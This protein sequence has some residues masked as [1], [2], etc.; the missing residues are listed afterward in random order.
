MHLIVHDAPNGLQGVYDLSS[1]NSI[2]R[3]LDEARVTPSTILRAAADFGVEEAYSVRLE[4]HGRYL[5][6]V[7]R[8]TPYALAMTFDAMT[9]ERLDPLSDSLM[10]A[11]AAEHLAGTKPVHVLGDVSE[12]H[13]DYDLRSVPAARISM[14]GDQPSELILSRASGRLLR[15]RD[16]VATGFE[17]WY[18][19]LH[20]FQW[21]GG[22]GGAMGAFT[23]LLYLV[24]A[25]VV[26]LGVL[27]IALWIWRWGKRRPAALTWHGRAGMTV[28]VFLLVEVLVGAYM[29]LSLGPLQD[30]F[31]GKNT[32]AMPTMGLAVSDSL[33]DPGTVIGRVAPALEVDPAA[34][35]MI[36]WRQIAEHPVWVVRT[37]RN[38]VGTVFSVRDAAP[39]EPVP[40]ETVGLAVQLLI[41]GNPRFS[42]R[43]QREYYWNDLN[44]AIP[45][46]HYRFADGTDV[47]ASQATAEIV[48][49]R[50]AFWR[51][52]SPFLMVHSVAFSADGDMN[53]I[54]LFI[55]LGAITTLLATGW[56]AWWSTRWRPS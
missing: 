24:T 19:A 39:W 38:E 3:R 55:M 28:G 12:Y 15:R 54:F 23:T 40:A 36:E 21:G 25:G 33:A 48:S 20:V 10:L 34:I 16:A 49:R 32:F 46:Y 31:R 42:Y 52:F 56:W 29:W 18:R 5:L 45:V 51:A 26:L 47:Y 2:I 50:T 53:A 37:A 35:Q 7:V 9:G 27:G 6:Y 44:R 13:R 14:D 43:G 8:P 1:G 22:G 17:A 41:N 11:I 30:P 4:S